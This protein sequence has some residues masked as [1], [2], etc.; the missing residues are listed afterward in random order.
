MIAFIDQQR[1]T[2]GVESICQ[3]LPIAPS[4]NYWHQE[5]REDSTRR[6]ARHLWQHGGDLL[7]RKALLLRGPP[8]V[9]PDCAARLALNVDRVSRGPSEVS[10]LS[11]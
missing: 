5:R 4:T 11:R 1:A 6:S 3:Q 8:A 7:H 10:R 2:Y 9:R